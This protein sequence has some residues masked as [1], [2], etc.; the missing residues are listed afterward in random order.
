MT[1]TSNGPTDVRRI[2]APASPPAEV[3]S[4]FVDGLT[5]QHEYPT[6]DAVQRLYDELD[7]Q[8]AC[9]VFLRNLL[10][11]SMYD[12]RAGLARDLGVD[13]PRAFAIWEGRMD[14]N[15]LLLTANTETLYSI[16]VVDLTDGPIVVVHP[17]LGDRYSRTSIWELHGDTRTIS[18]KQ[19]GGHPPAYAI[20]PLDTRER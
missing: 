17:D 4:R 2:T 8:R 15:S 14:A 18:Q 13:S 6:A 3:R 9:Q 16:A 5:F 11:A 12:F 7:F 10:A 1:F 20:L 19:D